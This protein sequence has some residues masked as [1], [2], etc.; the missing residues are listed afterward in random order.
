MGNAYPDSRDR[1][2]LLSNTGDRTIGPPAKTADR[3]D[4]HA[5][6][7]YYNECIW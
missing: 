6:F 4:I 3:N 7:S 1:E 2:W 5:F